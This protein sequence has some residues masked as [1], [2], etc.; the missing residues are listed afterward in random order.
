MLLQIS[1]CVI[2]ISMDEL[3]LVF[4]GWPMAMYRRLFKL[5]VAAAFNPR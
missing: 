1:R 4:Q 2:I 3:A 5:K